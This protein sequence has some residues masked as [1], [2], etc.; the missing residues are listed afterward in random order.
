MRLTDARANIEEKKEEG[1]FHI[2][3][4]FDL[5]EE[6]YNTALAN[7]DWLNDNEIRAM[8]Y[9]RSLDV[10]DYLMSEITNG[11]HRTYEERTGKKFVLRMDRN[12]N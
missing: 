11:L 12:F 2:T 8:F 10:A 9:G 1:K 4:S 5:V 3:L 7:M 6:D